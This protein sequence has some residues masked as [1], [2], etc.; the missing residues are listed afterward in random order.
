MCSTPPYG[1]SGFRL[2][3]CEGKFDGAVGQ[4]GEGISCVPESYATRDI[5]ERRIECDPCTS[6]NRGKPIDIKRSRKG[7]VAKM[8]GPGA[9]PAPVAFQPIDEATVLP[10]VAQHRTRGAP[11]VAAVQLKSKKPKLS[12]R[13][14]THGAALNAEIKAGPLSDRSGCVHRCFRRHVGGASSARQRRYR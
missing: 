11:G 9:D 6:T 5:K 2:I 7:C 4:I 3:L 1:P 12:L 8:T 14:A 10:V 13:V